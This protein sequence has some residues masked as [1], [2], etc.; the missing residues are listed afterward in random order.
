M[1][2]KQVC[3]LSR[4]QRRLLLEVWIPAHTP[5]TKSRQ[6]FNFSVSDNDRAAWDD[7]IDS[8]YVQPIEGKEDWFMLTSDTDGI[9]DTLVSMGV[10]DNGGGDFYFPFT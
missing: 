8:G 3:H 2:K 5:D 9:Y 4:K 6:Q 10:K 1:L 7:L